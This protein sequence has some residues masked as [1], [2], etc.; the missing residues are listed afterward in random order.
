MNRVEINVE[1][2]VNPTESYE[3]VEAAIRNVFPNARVE[4]R[5][6]GVVMAYLEG[7]DALTKLYNL[8]RRER[9]RSAARSVLRRGA[10]GKL[11]T[12]YLNKQAAYMERLSFSEPVGE[13]PLGPIKVQ[14]RCE[15]PE[16]LIRWLTEE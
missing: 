1:A 16:K 12:F 4:V 2:Q 3:K 14:I 13:S 15:E 10:E 8:L 6:E 5:E 7:L 11:I 9:I